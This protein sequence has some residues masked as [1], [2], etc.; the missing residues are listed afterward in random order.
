MASELTKKTLDIMADF[1][2]S[3]MKNQ[4]LF[5]C[6]Y[7]VAICACMPQKKNYHQRTFL[8]GDMGSSRNISC[9]GQGFVVMQIGEQLPWSHTV[10]VEYGQQERCVAAGHKNGGHL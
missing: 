3:M 4:V 2:G 6:H 7:I 5:L 9:C 10:R 1:K 8:L